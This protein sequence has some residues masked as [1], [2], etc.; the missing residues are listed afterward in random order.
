MKDEV[1]WN[2]RRQ[3]E[4]SDFSAGLIALKAERGG[5]RIEEKGA[6]DWNAVENVSARSIGKSS[7]GCL[8]EGSHI[9][10]KWPVS[11]IPVTYSKTFFQ[12][13]S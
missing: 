8:L 3:G 9:C 5:K 4:P 2:R 12:K 10:Q 11:S 1:C 7:Q 6:S 13:L